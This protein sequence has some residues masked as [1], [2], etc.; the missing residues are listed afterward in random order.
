MSATVSS[1]E[2]SLSQSNLK[3]KALQNIHTQFGILFINLIISDF[4]QALAFCLNWRWVV[5]RQAPALKTR[6]TVCVL[7]GVLINIGDVACGF[8]SLAIA[9]HTLNFLVIRRKPPN[10]V[11]YGTIAFVWTLNVVFVIAGPVW[12]HEHRGDAF[13]TW[14]RVWCFIN[15]R[16]FSSNPEAAFQY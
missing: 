14:T 12:A 3:P 5:L 16:S 7:Q 10:W 2:S 4:I 9:C 13:F 15:S 6:Q 8:W 11:I 1:K